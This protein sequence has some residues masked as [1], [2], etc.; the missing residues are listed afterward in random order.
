MAP[1]INEISEDDFKHRKLPLLFESSL[2]DRL[3]AIVGNGIFQFKFSWQSDTIHPFILNLENNITL[4]GIDLNFTAI[5]FDNGRILCNI[6]LDNFFYQAKIYCG[7]IYVI[8]EM[9]IIKVDLSSFVVLT[10]F[11]L[12]DFF[13]SIKFEKDVVEVKCVGGEVLFLR[14]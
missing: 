1:I 6:I 12:P 10:R 3:F 5:D 2:T 4:I 13:E 7:F 9:E 8:A 11:P 14:E